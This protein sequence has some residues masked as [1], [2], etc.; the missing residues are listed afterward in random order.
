MCNKYL[1]KDKLVDMNRDNTCVRNLIN[2]AWS[3][4]EAEDWEIEKDQWGFS[5]LEGFTVAFIK[6]WD[7]RKRIFLWQERFWVG[8]AFWGNHTVYSMTEEY[9]KSEKV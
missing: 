3:H 1:L 5:N 8:F 9:V 4:M 2:K 6:I 7:S